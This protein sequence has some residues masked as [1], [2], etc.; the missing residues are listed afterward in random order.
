MRGRAQ[1]SEHASQFSAPRMASF[2]VVIPDVVTQLGGSGEQVVVRTATRRATVGLSR[3]LRLG[4]ASGSAG[5]PR[6]CALS[7]EL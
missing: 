6:L 2:W 3:T 4:D 5:A 1:T 7:P